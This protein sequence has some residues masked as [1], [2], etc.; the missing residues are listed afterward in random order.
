[1]EK[2]TKLYVAELIDRD[3]ASAHIFRAFTTRDDAVRFLYEKYNNLLPTID[4]GTEYREWLE[5]ITPVSNRVR[6]FGVGNAEFKTEGY[7]TEVELP[8][9]GKNI[10][11]CV[12]WYIPIDDSEITYYATR[13][14]AIAYMNKEFKKSLNAYKKPKNVVEREDSCYADYEYKSE[15]NYGY[16]V[17]SVPVACGDRISGEGS[18]ATPK[19]EVGVKR[20]L[21]PASKITA[22]DHSGIC[23]FISVGNDVRTYQFDS[24]EKALEAFDIACAS[25]YKSFLLI[26]RTTETTTF[27]W[28]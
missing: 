8:V 23:V 13:E 1:M 12:E 11:A 19:R 5:G 16:Y 3:D 20:T 18:V 6:I 9:E 15:A 27:S 22:V 10:Y 28:L 2:T 21:F 17:V 14:K 24:E 7:L 4:K 25:L 26:E